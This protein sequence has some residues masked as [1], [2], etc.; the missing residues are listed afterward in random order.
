MLKKNITL[1]AAAALAGVTLMSAGPVQAADQAQPAA[2]ATASARVVPTQAVGRIVY[3]GRGKVALWSN[4]EKPHTITGYVANNTSWKVLSTA[5]LPDGH[6]MYSLGHNQWVDANYLKLADSSAN[7]KTAD[8]KPA[9][10]SFTVKNVSG[11]VVVTYHGRGKVA[12]WDNYT[13]PRHNTGNYVA[14]GS[15]WQASAIATNAN[16]EKWYKLGRQWLSAEYGYMVNEDAVVSGKQNNKQATKPS[17]KPTA[18]TG[19]VV[20]AYHG[21]QGAPV[22]SNYDGKTLV[23][24]VANNS[25]LQASQVV[26]DK[27]GKQ[28][29]K[30]GDNA[31]I[32]ADNAYLQWN[33]VNQDAKKGQSGTLRVVY[34]GRGKV[35]VWSGYGKDR[36][37]VKYLPKGSYWK[38]FDAAKDQAGNN[39]Y[40]LG[41]N[42]WISGEYVAL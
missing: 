32:S 4:Y 14:N 19:T 21:R 36:K 28:W 8:N 13:N 34:N 42:Q 29:F 24:R 30:I 26:K 39:W 6:I 20:V 1:L 33:T 12:L 15:R 22:Y 17:S 38:Y 5:V 11:V 31:W 18:E 7:T 9:D 2:T 37:V 41:G 23:R 16:G 10:S 27:S 3:N 25:R 40:N 35:A